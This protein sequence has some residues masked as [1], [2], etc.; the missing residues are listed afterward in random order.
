[1]SP[2]LKCKSVTSTCFLAH[3][4]CVTGDV[5]R[6]SQVTLGNQS[7]ITLGEYDQQDINNLTATVLSPSQR[8]EQCVLKRLANNR[9]GTSPLSTHQ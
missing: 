3:C 1:M 5:L 4:V 7:N 6:R 8:P 2:G 9:L